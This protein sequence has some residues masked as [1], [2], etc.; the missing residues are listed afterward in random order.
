MGHKAES[1]TSE[2]GKRTQLKG[3]VAKQF[4][5]KEKQG[6]WVAVPLSLTS[7]LAWRSFF[8]HVSGF[9]QGTEPAED[10]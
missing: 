2:L 8:S 4:D 1:R 7:S 3:K 9:N 10:T 6:V 5:K